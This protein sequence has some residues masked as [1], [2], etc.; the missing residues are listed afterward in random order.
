MF[1]GRAVPEIHADLGF[2]VENH[3]QVAQRPERRLGD[4]VERGDLDVGG[5]PTDAALG[6]PF[7]IGEK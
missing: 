1:A 2:G 7:Q 3:Q 4:R 6:S 5:D